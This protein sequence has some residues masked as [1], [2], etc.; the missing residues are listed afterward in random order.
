MMAHSVKGTTGLFF[1]NAAEMW[2]DVSTSKRAKGVAQIMR[3]LR[4]LLGAQQEEEV[5]Q[6]D[7][8]WMAE[9]GIIDM[10]VF[11]GPTPK[12]V[13]R[14]YS[15]LTG[16]TPLPPLFSLAYHQCRWNYNDQEDVSTVNR[17]FDEYDIPMD[18]IWLDI[19]HTDG[20]R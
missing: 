7:T 6:T 3:R 11:M 17:K 5:V 1:L 19:E 10:F 9:S 12:D 18:V 4:S 13:M 20:K 2:V 14:Q 16:T 15:S 8:H